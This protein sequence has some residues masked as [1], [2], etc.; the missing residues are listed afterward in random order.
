MAAIHR[1]LLFVVLPAYSVD[2]QLL[3]Y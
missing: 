2:N 1:M 3:I